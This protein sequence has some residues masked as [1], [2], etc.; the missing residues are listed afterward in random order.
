MQIISRLP[1]P[2]LNFQHG[3]PVQTDFLADALASRAQHAEWS[4]AETII[5]STL[6]GRCVALQRRAGVVSGLQ[7]S[8]S[9]VK[10]FW[11]DHADLTSEIDERRQNLIRSFPSNSV[12]VDPMLAFTHLLPH[13]AIICLGETLAS[14]PPET[15]PAEHQ[16]TATIYRERTIM[17]AREITRQARLIPRVAFCK[18]RSFS[19]L[20]SQFDEWPIFH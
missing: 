20:L 9:H 14:I 7:T 13:A 11:T 8:T 5:M 19:F 3:Q 10:D 4:F 12:L 16:F 17:A 1:A 18:V 2:E 15:V 6:L